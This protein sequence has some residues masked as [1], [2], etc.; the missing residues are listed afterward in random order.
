VLHVFAVVTTETRRAVRTISLE[1]PL[2][3]SA[4]P[5]PELR[6]LTRQVVVVASAAV[7]F[8]GLA[9]VTIVRWIRA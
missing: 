5:G 8:V 2:R 7:A 6:R 4:K 9:L 1:Q 3:G